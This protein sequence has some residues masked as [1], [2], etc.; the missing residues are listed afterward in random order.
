MKEGLI[1]DLQ[2]Q[3]KFFFNTLECLSEENSS[4][5]PQEEMLTVAQHVG[6]AAETIDWFFEGAFGSGFNMDFATFQENLKKYKSFDECVKQFTA[7]T[8][9]AIAKIKEVSDEELMSPIK[10]EIMTGAPK[11][12][13]TGALSDHTGHH[14]GALAVYARLLGKTPKMPYEGV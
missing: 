4:Y 6:H 13:V 7:A 3:Q 14:R 5:A 1:L 11:F 2:M 8:E 9:R 12:T 10:G